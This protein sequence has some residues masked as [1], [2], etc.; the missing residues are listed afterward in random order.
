MIKISPRSFLPT[1]PVSAMK[2]APSMS[3]VPIIF[4]SMSWTAICPEYHIGPLVVDAA[5]KVTSKPLDVHLM[6][7]NPDRYIP[8]F[9]TAGATSSPSIRK[10]YRICTVRFS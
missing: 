6:I 4:M 2:S 8:A 5:R 3:A 10:R 7:E 9:A 1:L